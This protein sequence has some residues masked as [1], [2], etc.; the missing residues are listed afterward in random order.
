MKKQKNL[1]KNNSLVQPLSMEDKA[2]YVARFIAHKGM[3]ELYGSIA[4][5]KSV[6][7]EI[8]QER[9]NQASVTVKKLN[10]EMFFID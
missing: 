2:R 8:F 6:A 10:G 9:W 4:Q 3:C 5:R 1:E 7:E